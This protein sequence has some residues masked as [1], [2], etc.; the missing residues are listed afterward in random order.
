MLDDVP[1]HFLL[2]SFGNAAF[3]IDPET[4]STAV[5]RPNGL[6][7]LAELIHYAIRNEIMSVKGA[8]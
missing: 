2:F 7:S 5:M 6:H 4:G 1:S 8:G 3:L